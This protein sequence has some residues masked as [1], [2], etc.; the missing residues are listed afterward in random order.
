MV[1]FIHHPFKKRNSR[2]RRVFLSKYVPL[3]LLD[4]LGI[5]LLYFVFTHANDYGRSVDEPL[6]DSS[7]HTALAWYRTHGKDTHFFTDHPDAYMPQHGIIFDV[8]LAWVQD[9]LRLKPD[10]EKYWQ[11]RA[12]I[13]G[14]TG[15]VGVGAIALCGYEL[16]GWWLALLAALGLCLYPRFFGAMFNNPKDVPFTSA[17][18]LVMWAV[19][20]LIKDWQYRYRFILTSLLLAFLIGLAASIRVNAILWY[21]ILAGMLGCWWLFRVG[22]LWRERKLI[23]PLLKSALAVVLIAGGSLLTM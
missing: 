4:I 14:L 12:E 18:I 1:V 16:G 3:S 11:V 23:L 8:C 22:Q 21:A 5:F 2:M 17:W 6:Q 13:T 20:R 9:H 15:V 7:G 10:M 19:L